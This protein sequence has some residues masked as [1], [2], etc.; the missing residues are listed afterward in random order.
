MSLIA[1]TQGA[2]DRVNVLSTRIILAFDYVL[3]TQ[4]SDF[5]DLDKRGF[6]FFF[7]R[8]LE[9]NAKSIEDR[10]FFVHP[11]A[12]HEGKTELFA[13]RLTEILK[14]RDL[15]SGKFVQARAGLLRS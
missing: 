7:A 3:Q 12:N 10:F 8:M 6:H 5:F 13:I 11:S 9:A 2:K 15:L 14:Q 4:I 1:K